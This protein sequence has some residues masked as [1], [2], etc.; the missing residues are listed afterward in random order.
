MESFLWGRR[1]VYSHNLAAGGVGIL[2]YKAERKG[3]VLESLGLGVRIPAWGLL[4][5]ENLTVQHS[6]CWYAFRKDLKRRTPKMDLAT[7]LVW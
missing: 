1:Q 7:L 2:Q 6:R 4:W 3:S 5:Q